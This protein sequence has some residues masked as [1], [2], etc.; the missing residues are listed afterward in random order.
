MARDVAAVVGLVTRQSSPEVEE[1]M[2][3]EK[4]ADNEEEKDWSLAE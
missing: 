4:V 2:E 1:A 3:E